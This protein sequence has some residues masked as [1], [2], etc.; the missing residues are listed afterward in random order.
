M[1]RRA[2]SPSLLTSSSSAYMVRPWDR[3]SALLEGA[4][5]HRR[6]RLLLLPADRLPAVPP[7]CRAE[8]HA[9]RLRAEADAEANARR[10]TVAQEQ[11]GEYLQQ[12]EA[13]TSALLARA[14]ALQQVLAALA[15]G[16]GGDPNASAAVAEMGRLVEELGVVAAE[17]R[18]S[19]AQLRAESGK[20]SSAQV[21]GWWVGFGAGQVRAWLGGPGMQ[22][23]SQLYASGSCW[24]GLVPT[25]LPPDPLPQP[26][27]SPAHPMHRPQANLAQGGDVEMKRQREEGGGE[28]SSGGMEEDEAEEGGVDGAAAPE[29]LAPE[30]MQQGFI[31]PQ[32]PPAA[33]AALAA[34]SKAAAADPDSFRQRARWVLGSHSLLDAA[35]GWQYMHEVGAVHAHQAAAGQRLRA[36]CHPTTPPLACLGF[37]QQVHSTAPQCRGAALAAPAGGGA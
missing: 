3:C 35:A 5:R 13:D 19:A 28:G 15:P 1:P 10:L 21:C 30:Q 26:P 7:A 37:S 2:L 32:V 20:R 16:A 9:G 14:Q 33:A 22:L 34:A 23:G 8:E 17:A 4:V 31:G 27:P 6:R 25:H 11:W 24:P 18:A 36:P 29:A 12:K